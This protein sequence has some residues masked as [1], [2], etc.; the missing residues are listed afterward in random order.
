MLIEPLIFTEIKKSNITSYHNAVPELIEKVQVLLIVYL[1]MGTTQVKMKNY[2]YAKVVLEH[3]WKMA[4]RLMGQGS[5]FEQKFFNK[6][7]I[8]DEFYQASKQNN[9]MHVSYIEND[10]NRIEGRKKKYR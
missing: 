1:N 5:Y 6:I 8:Y 4:R 10:D 7:N 3:G 9:N 2:K